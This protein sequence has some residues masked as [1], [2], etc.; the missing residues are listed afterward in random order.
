MTMVTFRQAT[1]ADAAAVNRL[2]ADNLEVGH[3]LPRTIEEILEHAPRFIVAEHDG[4]VIACAELAPLSATVAEV[5]SLVVDEQVRGNQIGPRLVTELAS[6]GA[7]RGFATL[8]AFTHQ[9]SHFV[10]LGFTIVPHMWVPEKIAHDCTSCPLFRRCGQ[11]AVTLPL[12]SG[13]HVRPEQPAALIYGGRTVGARRPNVERL[14]LQPSGAFAP[15]EEDT[16]AV[17]A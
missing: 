1:K 16:H 15:S 3:L 13:V 12:R 4:T 17:P 11:Y 7:S 10:K 2:I 6:A 5:R 8:C 9:P 14:H